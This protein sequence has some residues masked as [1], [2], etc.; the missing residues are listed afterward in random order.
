MTVPLLD[1]DIRSHAF[2]DSLVLQGVRQQIAPG[3]VIALVGASGCGK[4]TLLRIVSG[5]EQRHAGQVLLE[6]AP[7]RGLTRDIGIL[8]QDPR[9][10]PWLTVTENVAFNIGGTFRHLPGVAARIAA[11]LAEVGLTEQADALPRQLSAGQA[12][13]VAIARGLFIR[14]KLL[15]LDEPFSTVDAFTRLK[16]QDLLLAVAASHRVALLLATDDIDEAAY[17]ADRV[18]VLDGQTGS[19]SADISLDLPQPRQ[20]NGRA[21]AER[22]DTVLQALHAVHAA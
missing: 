11:L 13:R 3:E 21:L 22:H 12:Q 7:V 8:F 4:S 17:L 18:W 20:R 5:L 2:G 6:G 14:P 9:L 1:I 19:L 16:L 10:L 15:L